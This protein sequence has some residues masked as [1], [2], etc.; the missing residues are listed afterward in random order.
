MTGRLKQPGL[1]TSG[2]SHQPPS[3][4]RSV[5]GQICSEG[6]RHTERE[7]VRDGK[8]ETE[9]EKRRN[10]LRRGSDDPLESV[11][12]K[13]STV[14]VNFTLLTLDKSSADLNCSHQSQWKRLSCIVLLHFWGFTYKKRCKKL[15]QKYFK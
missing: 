5:D 9:R 11:H 12:E 15:C 14:E 7:G 8:S 10:I 4:T 6:E 2:S 13:S 3:L 1:V